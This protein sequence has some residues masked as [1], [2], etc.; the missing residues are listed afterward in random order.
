MTDYAR[1]GY[2][3]GQWP[4]AE[5]EYERLLSLPLYPA[6]TDRD[7]EDVIEALHKTWEA[8]RR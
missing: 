3:R 2:A 5:R 4:V 6:M 8:Y 7:L 1:L